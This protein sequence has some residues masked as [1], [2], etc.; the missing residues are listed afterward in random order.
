MQTQLVALDGRLSELSARLQKLEEPSEI[1]KVLMDQV[2]DLTVAEPAGQD[3]TRPDPDGSDSP[4]P[5]P[6]DMRRLVGWVGVNI[7]SVVE[8]GIATQSTKAPYWCRRWWDHPEAIVRFEAARRA[9]LGA[10]TQADTDAMSAYLN[11]LDHHLAVMQG[12]DGTFSLCKPDR[13]NAQDLSTRCLGQD[14]PDE[15]F[16]TSDPGLPTRPDTP[17]LAGTAQGDPRR[18]TPYPRA[19]PATGGDPTRGVDRH[20]VARGR[21]W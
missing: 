4:E 2:A 15:S 1:Q 9:W 16:Y 11:H 17:D 19:N 12:P 7:A 10:V 8:R 21:G 14:E 5:E 6:F 20:R 3:P 18:P 13:H